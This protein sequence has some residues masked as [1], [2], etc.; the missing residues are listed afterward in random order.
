MISHI[1]N[2]IRSILFCSGHFR[3]QD[4]NL[5]A[6]ASRS[7]GMYYAPSLFCFV[8]LSLFTVRMHITID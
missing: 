7:R 3:Y 8:S 6:L 4:Y 1:T 2:I 5:F